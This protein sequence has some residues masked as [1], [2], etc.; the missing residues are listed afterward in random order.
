M[1]R[2]PLI[3]VAL[4]AV[5]VAACPGTNDGEGEGEGAG[6]G[7]RFG[8]DDFDAGRSVIRSICGT[9]EEAGDEDCII[10][11]SVV[12]GVERTQRLHVFNNSDAPIALTSAA[13]DDVVSFP[14]VDEVLEPRAS[15]IVLVTARADEEGVFTS[16]ITLDGTTI[17]GRAEAEDVG[18]CDDALFVDAFDDDG[19][20]LFVIGDEVVPEVSIDAC[21]SKIGLG[22]ITFSFEQRPEGAT[23]EIGA[24]GR[25]TPDVAGIWIIAADA[26]DGLERPLHGTATVIVPVP[27]TTLHATT[28]SGALSLVKNPTNNDAFCAADVCSAVACD[29]VAGAFVDDATF[30]GALPAGAYRF[31]ISGDGAAAFDL[32]F[33]D[34]NTA[35]VDIADVG[36]ITDVGVILFVE[37]G[38]GFAI[39]EA[40]QVVACP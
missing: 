9:D 11:F 17:T 28:S 2:A 5:A 13:V 7:L 38:A 14:A 34:D 25:F 3:A 40:A 33:D 32:A 10:D 24:D 6:G 26:V 1:R 36:G 19:D 37:G 29:I 23:A 39:V 22:A 31:A 12:I 27:F 8:I 21:L 35:H 16:S 15:T 30:A 4:V 18:D 20:N